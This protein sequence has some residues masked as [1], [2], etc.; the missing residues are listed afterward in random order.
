[1][2]VADEGAP[3]VAADRYTVALDNAAVGQRKLG[4]QLGAQSQAA[5]P[6]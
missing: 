4:H 2:A 6:A 5:L 1:M 3:C